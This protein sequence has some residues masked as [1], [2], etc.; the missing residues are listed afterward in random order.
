MFEKGVRFY[1]KGT[2]VLEVPFPED[3]VYCRWCPWCRSE[4]ESSRHRCAL[5]NEILYTLDFR[6]DG[7]PIE[8][9]S[10]EEK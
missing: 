7:C 6:S 9:P 4:R 10:M 3:E 1:T 2:V 8:I 5:T